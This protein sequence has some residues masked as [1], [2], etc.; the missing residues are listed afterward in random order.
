M[1]FPGALG[2]INYRL[3]SRHR[4][5][6]GIHSPFVY[7]LIS[8]VFRNKIDPDIVLTIENIRKKNLSDGSKINFI[9]LGAGSSRMRTNS[10]RVSDIAKYSSVPC[11]Y[12]ILLHNMAAHFG[13]P[14]M[15]EFGTSLGISTIYLASGCPGSIV[16]SMEGCPESA[17]IAMEN[18]KK[19]DLS[20]IKLLNGSFDELLQE[21]KGMAGTPGLIFIDG[22]H[23][24]EPLMKY[25]STMSEISGDD[26]V[27]I[28]DDIHSSKEM[29][30]AWGKIKQF[31]NI[32]CTVDI[33][34]MGM[35][36]FRKGIDHTDYIIRY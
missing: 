35:V 33:F 16:Y 15:I 34:R 8:E 28:I 29:E 9:D 18:F 17:G 32:S 21:V 30:N 24:Q 10:R 14:A 3:F 23:R 12:G 1:N 7:T 13:K 5:G 2:L 22:N 4:K 19:A 20:N 27:I 25:F 26:T 11:K 6:H 36:F 31:D